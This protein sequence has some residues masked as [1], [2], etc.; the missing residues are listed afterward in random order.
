VPQ[1]SEWRGGEKLFFGRV[2][3][4]VYRKKNPRPEKIRDGDSL[5]SYLQK[6][7]SSDTTNVMLCL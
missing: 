6:N 7:Y 5:K 4:F 1:R 2:F 3:E